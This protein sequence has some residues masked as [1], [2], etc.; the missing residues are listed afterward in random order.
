MMTY[1]IVMVSLFIVGVCIESFVIP[2]L[3]PDNKFKIWWKNHIIDEDPDH[4]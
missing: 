4:L 2:H 3:N 1:I